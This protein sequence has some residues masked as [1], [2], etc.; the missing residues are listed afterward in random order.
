MMQDK[1]E[2]HWTQAL[3]RLAVLTGACLGKGLQE[4]APMPLDA[5]APLEWRWAPAVARSGSG[6]APAQRWHWALVPPDAFLGQAYRGVLGREP[7]PSGEA[8][9]APW[10]NDWLG[11][12]AVLAA[13]VDSDE[14][15]A[16]GA[17][18]EGVRNWA[19]VWHA[20]R[21]WRLRSVAQALGGWLWR[22]DAVHALV[23]GVQARDDALQVWALQLQRMMAA[24]HRAQAAGDAEL[25]AIDAR[26]TALGQTLLELSSQ[27]GGCAGAERHRPSETALSA[28]VPESFYQA[29]EAAFRPAEQVQQTV[30]EHLPRIAPFWGEL[31]VDIGCGRADWLWVAQGHG[32]RVLGV[33]PNAALAQQ[34]LA[35][36]VPVVVADGLAWL[37]TQPEGRAAVV[38]LLHVAEHLPFGML[39]QWLQEIGRVLRPG[40]MVLLET[41]N[42]ENGYVGSHLFYKDPTHLHPLPPDLLRFALSWCGFERVE[43]A[44][45]HPLPGRIDAADAASERLNGWL[46]GPQDYVVVGYRP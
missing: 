27:T 12:V 38:T 28:A 9:Y 44:G 31:I 11:R 10:L 22:R 45:L 26:L 1:D 14:G 24:W 37:Q 20:L 6:A 5:D 13:L 39:L 35:A 8:A 40:G 4:A 32:H 34:A 29:L 7:D 17:V 19:R 15:R 21:N 43:V 46:H 16:H 36:G 3:Q 42:P 25:A 41:P 23:H 18:V 30:R 33:E 2:E